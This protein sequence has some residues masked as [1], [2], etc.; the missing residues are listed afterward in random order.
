MDKDT[1]EY[2]T[3]KEVADAIETIQKYCDKQ[4]GCS[5]CPIKRWCETCTAREPLD[6]RL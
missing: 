4:L 5:L 1:I 2:M 6:W 3:Y